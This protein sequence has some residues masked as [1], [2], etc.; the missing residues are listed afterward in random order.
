M[1]LLRA[2]T[3][4]WKVLADDASSILPVEFDQVT[5]PLIKGTQN[6]LVK[7]V[8]FAQIF[9]KPWF[10]VLKGGYIA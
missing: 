7:M 10:W 6:N 4:K 8:V 3:T 9:V 2:H 5:L 1:W